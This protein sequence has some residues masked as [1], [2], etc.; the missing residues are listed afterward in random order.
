[1]RELWLISIIKIVSS[2]H[3]ALCCSKLMDESLTTY[4]EKPNI[5]F[6]RRISILHDV[7]DQFSQSQLYVY[8]KNELA[9]LDKISNNQ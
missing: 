3:I 8:A 4:A 5:S 1:M 2:V 6:Q 9:F 7:A